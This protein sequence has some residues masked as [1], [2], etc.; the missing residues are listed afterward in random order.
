MVTKWALKFKSSLIR[1]SVW[2]KPFSKYAGSKKK[3]A[4]PILS[5]AAS[6]TVQKFCRLSFN[7]KRV[8]NKS[9]GQK[10]KIIMLWVDKKTKK[11]KIKNRK[12]FLLPV[13]INCKT[14]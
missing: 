9:I 4:K 10:N 14:K 13:L 5:K 7:Q 6:R 12:F 8:H 11:L 3:Q 2:T 1:L